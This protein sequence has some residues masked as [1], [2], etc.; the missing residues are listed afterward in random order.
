M[1]RKLD[2]DTPRSK[3]VT[4]RLNE[5]EQEELGEKMQLRGLTDRSAYFRQVMHEDEGPR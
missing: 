4:L 2:G 1:V 3:V 5:G